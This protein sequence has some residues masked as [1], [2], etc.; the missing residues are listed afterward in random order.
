MTPGAVGAKYRIKS[1]FEIFQ[2]P[3]FVKT[4]LVGIDNGFYVGS[5]TSANHKEAQKAQNASCDFC[6]FLWLSVG[7]EAVEQSG[8]AGR[9]ELLQAATLRSMDRVPGV[10]ARVASQAISVAEHRLRVGVA[11]GPV[12]A[13]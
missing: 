12:L 10:Y 5:T 7:R 9:R 6:A 13:C 4:H 1:V 11:D 3:L 2:R 8:S